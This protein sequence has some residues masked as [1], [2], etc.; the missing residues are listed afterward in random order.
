V[1]TYGLLVYRE[2]PEVDSLRIA[3]VAIAGS[4]G[5]TWT[6]EATCARAQLP[7]ALVSIMEILGNLR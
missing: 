5:K 6:V 1:V 3:A 4:A 2:A 7:A